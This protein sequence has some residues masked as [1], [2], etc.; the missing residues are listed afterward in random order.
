MNTTTEIRGRPR[1]NNHSRVGGLC[2]LQGRA[3]CYPIVT[4]ERRNIKEKIHSRV[5]SANIVSHGDNFGSKWAGH[6]RVS[7]VEEGGFQVQARQR[8]FFFLPRK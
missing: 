2:D 8:F 7:F 6:C 1:D 5:V 3:L 4:R